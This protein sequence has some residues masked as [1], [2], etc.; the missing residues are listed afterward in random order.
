MLA[1]SERES[2]RFSASYHV[3]AFTD[4]NAISQLIGATEEAGAKLGRAVRLKLVKA[5]HEQGIVDNLKTRL[6]VPGT[7]QGVSQRRS[8]LAVLCREDVTRVPS[9]FMNGQLLCIRDDGLQVAQDLALREYGPVLCVEHVEPI[10]ATNESAHIDRRGKW[11]S[12]KI[13][14]AEG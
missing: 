5:H 1:K 11:F 7:G 4:L 12:Y 6:V 13:A 10:Q 9:H 14:R 8:D 3:N 2:R